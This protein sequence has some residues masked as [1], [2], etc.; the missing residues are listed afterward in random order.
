MFPNLKKNFKIITNLIISLYLF[1]EKK[2]L[3]IGSF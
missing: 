1:I 2:K 3:P